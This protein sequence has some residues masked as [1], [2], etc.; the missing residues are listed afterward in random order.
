LG[1]AVAEGNIFLKTAGSSSWFLA[2]TLLN[3]KRR[4]DNRQVS[5]SSR[6]TERLTM[7]GKSAFRLRT[8]A[9]RD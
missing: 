8:Q 6:G 2:R 3:G 7:L 9:A 1:H 4:F 5:L